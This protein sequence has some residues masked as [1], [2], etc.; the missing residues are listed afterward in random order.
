[1]ELLNI[2]DLQGVRVVGFDLYYQN[3]QGDIVVVQDALVKIAS[4]QMEVTSAGD[5]VS[6]TQIVSASN[7]NLSQVESVFL[8]NV[9]TENGAN[10]GDGTPPIDE[11][12]DQLRLRLEQE[13]AERAA[14][15]ELLEQQAAQLEEL[16]EE[17][18]TREAELAARESA[19]EAASDSDLAND[20]ERL[21]D[22]LNAQAYITQLQQE[23][24]DLSE[25][26]S[27]EAEAK[28]VGD[29]NGTGYRK[30]L[31]QPVVEQVSVLASRTSNRRGDVEEEEA[32]I[33]T[34][35]LDSTSD[36][37][38]QGDFITNVNESLRFIGRANPGAAVAI[39]VNGET[40]LTTAD[41]AGTWAIIAN[42]EF[43]DGSYPVIVSTTTLQ[44]NSTTI[45]KLLVIDTVAPE[46]PSASLA[47]ESDTGAS[48]SD[49][50]TNDVFAIFEGQAEPTSTV[51]LTVDGRTYTTKASAE[52][53][54]KIQALTRLTDE[55]DKPYQVTSEDVA[56]NQSPAFVD[57][58]TVDT[59]IQLEGGLMAEVDSNI[60]GDEVT[61]H[62]RPL[63][64]GTADADASVVL[65]LD[66]RVWNTDV[67]EDGHWTIDPDIQL[68]DGRYEYQLSATD[69]AGNTKLLDKVLVIDTVP[70]ELSARLDSASDSGESDSD[71]ITNVTTPR[72]SG[73][74][75][76]N[77]QVELTINESV[78]STRSNADGAWFIQ[79][80]E[81]LDEG[82]YEYSAMATDLAGNQTLISSDVTIDVRASLFGRLAPES[83]SGLFDDDQ[84][85]KVNQPKF[86]G[87]ADPGSVVT[88]TI[89]NQEH[90]TRSDLDGNWE[91]T[92]SQSLPDGVYGYEITSVD[93]AGNTALP[94]QNSVVIDTVIDLTARLDPTSDTGR[95][96]DDGITN[97]QTPLLSGRSEAGA[98]VEL[99]VNGNQYS[100]TV[101]Q[102]NTWSIAIPDP[103]Q[104]G[105]YD[106]E[107]TATDIAGNTV[108]VMDRF[109]VDTLVPVPFTAEL[110]PAS[111]SG[112][113]ES[114]HI[115]NVVRP[116]FK[117][118]AEADADVVLFMKLG[119]AEVVRTDV[120]VGQDLAWE[121]TVPE[122][123]VDGQYD[124]VLHAVDAAGNET[125]PVSGQLIIDTVLELTGGLDPASDTGAS[126]SD[127][128][129]RINTPS[130]SGEGEPGAIVTL[131]LGDQE[132]DTKVDE[133]GIWQ[134]QLSEALADGDYPY[135]LNAV[136][137]AG[138][139]LAQPLTDTIRIDTID[140]LD[141][142]AR[143]APESD[144]GV[145][146]SDQLTAISRPQ[147]TGTVEPGARVTLEIDGQQ[148]EANV[149]DQGS[150]TVTVTTALPDG[151]HAYQVVAE[152]LAGNTTS[153]TGEVVIDTQ[154]RLTGGLA[155]FSDTGVSD[156]D[157]LTRDKQ[158]T[159]AGTAEPQA[160]VTLAIAEQEYSTQ[161][162]SDGLWQIQVAEV[163]ADDEYSYSLISEDL[164]G[165]TASLN[166][167][168]E[169]DSQIFLTARLA[170]QSDS[171]VSSSDNITNITTPILRGTAEAGALVTV[172]IGGV[173]YETRADDNEQWSVQVVEPLADGI[174]QY[175]VRAEDDAG[176]QERVEQAFIVDTLAP[177]LT[178][179][180]DQGSDTG[181][182]SVDGITR[183]NTPTFSGTGEPGA[184]LVLTLGNEQ[185]ET[186]IDPNG[187]W[188]VAIE[189]PL[190]DGPYT[191]GIRASD[192]AGN[193]S[194]LTG[195]IHIDTQ[196]SFT[197]RLTPDSDTGA[198]NTDGITQITLPSFDGTGDAGDQVTLKIASTEYTTTVGED[199]R[200]Q[201]SVTDELNEGVHAYTLESR[202]LAGNTSQILDSITVDTTAPLNFTGGLAPTSD[203]GRSAEDG[204]TNVTR[205]SFSGLVEQGAKVRL[206]INDIKYDAEVS[207]N[208]QW[209]VTLPISLAD[210]TY[211]YELIATDLAGNK[212]LLADRIIV[213]TKTELSGGLDAESDSGV[214]SSDG[215]TNVSEPIFSGLGEPNAQVA[216]TIANRTYTSM[217]GENGEWSV[218]VDDT[219]VD[220]SHDYVITATDVAGNTDSLNGEIRVD[221]Q[222]SLTARL[223][224][225]SDSGWYRDDG[226]TN[227][228]RPF[229]S[230]SGE[231]GAS[232]ELTINNQT[233]QTQV[234]RTGQWSL[235]VTEELAD[236]EHSYHVISLDD[237]GNE[238]QASGTVV[239]DTIA[240]APLTASL[241]PASDSG[242]SSSDGI[243]NVST[244][245]LVGTGEEGARISVN[246]G[247]HSLTATVSEDGTWF[248]D[249]PQL[250]ADG[251]IHYEVLQTDVAGNTSTL[252]G[253]F[254]LDTQMAQI[255]GGLSQISDSGRSASDG[256]TNVQQPRFHGIAEK[257]ALVTLAIANQ[258]FSTTADG[259]GNWSIQVDENLP[260]GPLPY[261]ITGED[262]AGNTSSL[263]GV[264]TVDTQAPSPFTAALSPDSDTG[265]SSTD[266]ITNNSTPTFAGVAE[267][268]A[269]IV[270]SLDGQRLTT[271]AGD[272]GQWQVTVT[273]ELA[274][275]EYRFTAVATDIA[276][277]VTD[278]I[279]SAFEIDLDTF[280]TGGLAAES[281]TGD[282][283]SDGL[284]KE[285][286]PV[287]YGSTEVGARVV[288]TIEG[289]TIDADV[290]SQG[291]WVARVTDPLTEG[292]IEYRM[293]AT[294]IAGN[295]ATEVGTF[296]LDTT[297][298]TPFTMVL[299]EESDSGAI[300]DG[301]TNEQTPTFTGTGEAGALVTL[302][303]DGQTH[304]TRVSSGGVWSITFDPLNDGVKVIQAISSDAAGNQTT[305][306]V[307]DLTIDTQTSVTGRLSA[308]S[309]LGFSNSD[310]ITS[311]D[312]PR[313]V[314]TG[315]AG[316]TVA[317]QIDDA[318][319]ETTVTPEGN[320]QID[321]TE[322][323][324]EGTLDYTITATD[325]ADNKAT[326]GG[327][328]VIDRTAPTEFTGRLAPSSDTGTSNSDGLT[329]DRTPEFEGIGEPGARVT[330]LLDNRQTRTTVDEDGNWSLVPTR[331]LTSDG[332][333]NYV[334]TIMD[335]AGNTRSL[336]G[337][338]VLDTQAQLTGG[339]DYT[340]DTGISMSDRLTN[341]ATPMFSGTADPN[342]VVTL[343]IEGEDYTTTAGSNGRWQVTVDKALTD[344]SNGTV[345]DY[346]IN[347][348]DPAGN[349]ASAVEGNFTLDLVAPV[350]FEGG[351]DARSDLGASNSDGITNDTTPTFSGVV[352]PGSTV[353]LE[354]NNKQFNATV[355]GS[356]NWQFSLPSSEQLA[357]GV[358]P[359]T[360]RATDGAGNI[361]AINKTLTID[362]T[363]PELFARL[364]PASDSGDSNQDAITNIVTPS[365][366]G[367]TEP[368]AVVELIIAGQA[369]FASVDENGD[370]Q[371]EVTDALGEGTHDYTVTAIDLAGNQTEQKQTI[372][373]D[374]TA[375]TPFTARLD[376]S[377]DSGV[378]NEDGLTNIVRPMISGTAEVDSHIKV[379]IGGQEY[380]TDADANGA[381]SVQV[382]TALEQGSHSFTAT[383]TDKAGN[384]T[385][386]INGDVTIDTQTSVTGRLSADSDTG[387]SNSD[388]LTNDATP[389]FNGVAE[390]GA[391]VTLTIGDNTYSAAVDET[392]AWV[393]N[394][395]DTL[396][397]GNQAYRINSTDKAGNTDAEAGVIVVDTTAP[398]QPFSIIL[399]RDSDSGVSQTDGITRI[400]APAFTGQA[401]VSGLVT[402]VI[403]GVTRSTTANESGIWRIAFPDLAEGDKSAQ[404]TVTD[405]AGNIA[406]MANYDFTID[407]QTYVSGA[408]SPESDT[409]FFSTDEISN[410][411]QPYF[412][413]V[414]EPGSSITLTIQDRTYSSMVSSDGTWEVQ[415]TTPLPEG[416]H[417]YTITAEDIAGNTATDVGQVVI[418]LTAPIGFSGGLDPLSDTGASNSDLLT[419]E[420]L[421]TFSGTSE[422]GSKVTLNLND[423]SITVD[424]DEQGTWR[425]TLDEPLVDQG[426]YN[427]SLVAEDIA[428]NTRELTGAFE[429]DLV[430]HLTGRLAASSD[431][432]FSNN[433]N[434]TNDTTPTFTGEAESG[435][436]VTLAINGQTYRTRLAD[437]ETSW[438]IQVTDELPEG[439]HDY[440]IES[441][442]YAGN[443]ATPVTG[444]LV[445]DTTAPTPF[446]GGLAQDSTSDTGRA[447]DDSITNNR[448]PT[449]TGTVEDG[450]KVLLKINNATFEASVEGTTWS[451]TLQPGQEL[452]ANGT[453]TYTVE[454]Q[455]QAGN[456]AQINRT[457]TL[458][459][460]APK[461]T[462]RLAAE[463]DTGRSN[464]DRITADT[465]PVIRGVSDPDADISVTFASTGATYET[466]ADQLGNWSITV[467]ESNALAEGVQTYTVS[468]TDVAGNRTTVNSEGFEVDTTAPTG[469]SARLSA[470]S[471]SA[472]E[473][474]S[475]GTDSDGITNVLAPTVSGSVEEGSSVRVTIA[476]NQYNAQ[477]DGSNWSLTLPPLGQ[478][479][480]SFSAVATDAAGNSTA[481]I[482]VAFTIDN[483]IT[484]FSGGLQ[485]ASDSGF[486][487][488]DGLTNVTQPT[489]A[490]N[491]E[492]GSVVLLTIG[493]TSY[494]AVVDP[495]TGNW[496][497]KVTDDLADGQYEYSLTAVDIAGN[498]ERL[499]GAIEIDTQISTE[500]FTIA[501]DPASDSATKGD[502]LTNINV[503]RVTGSGEP[504]ALITLSVDGQTRTTMVDDNG[505][506]SAELGTLVDGD[507]TVEGTQT[508][509][510]GNTSAPITTQFTVDTETFVTARLDPQ[511]DF[512]NS[513][514]DG[515]TNTEIPVFSGTGE[516]GST[517][518]LELN[519]QSYTATVQAGG[520]WSVSIPQANALSSG[521]YSYSVT[522][523]DLAGNSASASGSVTI[524]L[525]APTVQIDTIADDDVINIAE[526]T[527]SLTISGSTVGVE[528]N[529][530]L[531][532]TLN[533]ESYNT[534]V[535]D[536]QFAIE[537]PRGH[538]AQLTNSEYEVQAS[539]ADVAGNRTAATRTLATDLTAPVVAISTIAEDDYINADE[540]ERG[541]VINGL[542]NGAE[543]GQVVNISVGAS[544]YQTTVDN[545]AWRLA[546]SPE[547]LTLLP[548]NQSTRV[549]AS[550]TDQAG[551]PSNTATRDVIKDIT[552]P[553][554]SIGEIA[555]DNVINLQESQSPVLIT[556]TTEGVENGGQVEIVLNGKT[557]T[558]E[559]NNGSWSVEIGATDVGAL[560]DG[561]RFPV[562]AK[563]ADVAGNV[564]EATKSLSVDKTIPLVSIGTIS[565]DGNLNKAEAGQPIEISGTTEGVENG[566][567]VIVTLN[568]ASYSA[569]VQN[570]QW[571]LSI[572]SISAANL[573]DGQTY[574]VTADVKDRA[575]NPA[576]QAV[577]TLT[578]DFTSPTLTIDVISDD[579][580]INEVEASSSVIISGTSD[581]ENGQ[582]VAIQLGNYTTSATVQNGLWTSSVP[583]SV[584]RQLADGEY[585]VS[586]D[587]S[588]LAGN[589][590]QTAVQTVTLDT[591]TP[592]IRV[593]PIAGDGVLNA[594]EQG[595][596]L[597]ISGT[598]DDVEDGQQ[599]SV[600]LND[601]DYLA[602]VTDNAWSL[603]I[604]A[605]D[606]DRLED[607]VQYQ[608]EM[609]VLD[610]AG[611]RGS[612]SEMLRTDFTAP[613][614]T[615]NDLGDNVLNIAERGESLEITGV[616]EGAELGQTIRVSFNGQNYA[617]TVRADGVWTVTVPV[618]RLAT[619]E[620]D[621]HYEIQAN[622]SDSAGNPAV[623]A[624][625]NLATDFTPPVVTFDAISEDTG[626]RYDDSTGRDFYTSD[627][628][629]IFTG[630]TEAGA[631]V[632]VY[633]GNHQLLGQAVVESNGA[634]V[635]DHSNTVLSDGEHTF[636]VVATDAAGNDSS[637]VQ[638]LVTVDTA[639]PMVSISHLSPDTGASTSDGITN[640]QALRF[641]GSA[642]ANAWVE[643]S[644][645]SQAI[646]RVKS[647][648]GG[649]WV[650]DYSQTVIPEGSYVLTAVALDKAG[651]RSTTDTLEFEVDI[652]SP[653]AAITTMV[654]DTNINNDWHTYH[655][656]PGFSGS[657]D[658]GSTVRI[659]LDD[660]QVKVISQVAQSGTWTLSFE[661]YQAAL[662]NIARLGDGDHTIRLSVTDLAGNSATVNQAFV[663]DSVAP[664]VTID[665]I[666][667]DTKI[668]GD[669]Y[670]SDGTLTFSG[671]SE[672]GASV[673]LAINGNQI[674]TL[675][676][677]QDG[678]WSYQHNVD[679][680][681]GDYQLTATAYDLAGNSSVA[682]QAFTVDK[683][684]PD[685]VEASLAQDTGASSTDWVTQNGQINVTGIEADST[686]QYSTDGGARWQN[687]QGS[688][689]T[690]PANASFGVNQVQIKQIDLAG[691]ES[692][693][694][695]NASPI[696]T[697]TVV[698]PLSLALQE[699]TGIRNDDW[700]TQNRTLIVTGIESQAT[701]EYS[702]NHGESWTN[703]SGNSFS[704]QDNYSYAAEQVQVRQTDLAGNVSTVVKAPA[705]KVD[706][707]KPATLTV[708]M[709]SDTG[710]S[711][712]DWIS[713]DGQIN[714]SGVEANA[715]WKYRT[716]SD[717]PWIEVTS[718][719]SFVL[720]EGRYN[721]GE[722]QV[723]QEDLAG[724]VST[725]WTSPQTIEVDKT[726]YSAP[727][728]TLVDDTGALSNDWVTKDGRFEVSN[729]E[730][731][732]IWQYS[733]NGGASWTR[734]I[735]DS[736][737]VPEG[738]Y[739]SGM[740]QVLQTDVAGNTSEKWASTQRLT[741]DTTAPAL[742]SLSLIEDTGVSN[743][744]QYTQNGLIQVTGVESGA[745]WEYSLNNGATWV[746]G[747]TNSNQFQL[748]DNTTYESGRVQVRQ[749]D[750]AGNV[751]EA[752][753]LGRVV[754]DTNAPN[755]PTVVLAEDTGESSSDWISRN[756]QLNVGTEDHA[757]WFYSLDGGNTYTQ[758]A[759]SNFT[760]KEGTYLS[761]R[762]QVYQEDLAGNR[763]AIWVA[764]EI[765]IITTPPAVKSVKLQAGYDTGLSDN[766]MITNRTELKFEGAVDGNVEQVTVTFNGE[767]VV[768]DVNNGAWEFVPRNSLADGDYSISAYAT[769]IAGNVS[770]TLEEQV[771]VDTSN[772]EPP[773][774]LILVTDS[775]VQGDNKTNV[776]TPSFRGTADPNSR[777]DMTFELE[778]GEKIA[779]ATRANSVGNWT[780]QVGDELPEGVHNYFA[781][782]TDLAGNGSAS[783]TRG[784]VEIDLTPPILESVEMLNSEG[785]VLGQWLTN[786]EAGRYTVTGESEPNAKVLL[787][788]NGTSIGE[789]VVNEAGVFEYEFD[790]QTL[791]EG[792]YDIRVEA[793][794]E[795]GN[796]SVPYTN[797]LI[798]DR[799]I[800]LTGGLATAS[801]SGV[802]NNDGITF[803]TT[804]VFQGTTDPDATVTIAIQ[805]RG[806]VEIVADSQGEWRYQVSSDLADGTYTWEISAIDNAGNSTKELDRNL[807][808]TLRVDTQAP[809]LSGVA[810]EAEFI[811]GSD[812]ITTDR[813]ITITGT[814]EANAYITLTI[815]DKE[816][817]TRAEGTGDFSIKTTT[818]SYGSHTYTVL[819]S[820]A[821][822]NRTEF[823]DD[824]VIQADY[825]PL[826]IDL[827]DS[828]NS[829]SLDDLL[830]NAK[831]PI[832]AGLATPGSDVTLVV[833]NSSGQQVATYR[834]TPSTSGSWQIAVDQDLADGDY[835]FSATSS[836][837]G[838]Q[839]DNETLN[840][841][842]D[843]V[844]E[845]TFGISK[846]TDSSGGLGI[847]NASAVE[848]TGVSDPDAQVT[849]TVFNDSNQQVSI[850]SVETAADGS[851]LLAIPGL[852]DG[853]YK[854]VVS[855][856]DQAGNL[857]GGN[858]E[859]T[860]SVT[861]DRVK[862]VI[863]ATLHPEDD[864]GVSDSDGIT[865]IAKPRFTG[866][867]Q[868]NY[869]HIY[870]YVGNTSIN[871]YRED[872]QGNPAVNLVDDEGNWTFRWQ[873]T[874]QDGI[875]NYGV[876]ARDAAKN[877]MVASGQIQ[878][879]TKIDFTTYLEGDSGELSNDFITNNTSLVFKG[880]TEPGNVIEGRL[881]DS[882]N[883]LL[884]TV[885]ITA[886]N[887]G[888]Y[889]AD[890]GDDY[891]D[892]VYRVEFD[893]SDAAGNHFE[894]PID[895][896]KIDTAIDTLTL[897]FD[898]TSDTGN[899]ELWGESVRSDG[900]TR[901]ILPTF[902]G[903]GEP[904][905]NVS[906]TITNAAGDVLEENT[907]NVTSA[908]SWSY[909][910]N[911]SL[912]DGDYRIAATSKDIAG[913][914]SL[915]PTVFDFTVKTTDP[916]L[917]WQN[918]DDTNGDGIINQREYE[919]SEVPGVLSF[920]GTGDPGD[921]VS[922]VIA[923]Q[924]Y[925]T[926]VT[927][928]GTW[929]LKTQELPDFEYAFY[930]Q[931][932]DRAGN[933]TTENA[934]VILDSG[935]TAGI[936]MLLADDTAVK[937]DN[938]TKNP[939]PRFA[940]D[941]EKGDTLTVTVT[942]DSAD[943]E[944]F[945]KE[946]FVADSNRPYW[947]LPE[948]TVY[949][950][951]EYSVKVHAIDIG[952]NE[953]ISPGLTFVID[954][955]VNEQ[956]PVEISYGSE[957]D[958]R[959]A[960]DE[961][962][963]TNIGQFSVRSQ[964]EEEIYDLQIDPVNKDI[965]GD[966]MRFSSD[967][968][969]NRFDIR[970]PQ[971]LADGRHELLVTWVDQAGNALS[972]TITVDIKSELEVSDWQVDN[973]VKDGAF[974]YSAD[975]HASF[976]GV[977]DAGATV[978]IKLD[979]ETHTVQAGA[980]G[981]WQLTIEDLFDG[982]YT[983]SVNVNDQWGNWSRSGDQLLV[984]DTF[985]PVLTYTGGS[986][987]LD[988]GDDILWN[989][990]ARLLSGRTEPTAVLS[991]AIEG[992]EPQNLT[993]SRGRWEF[994]MAEYDDGA[995]DVEL[996]S[997]DQAGNQTIESFTITI[998]TLAPEVTDGGLTDASDTGLSQTDSIT[999]LT[1000]PT[1001][1002][1003]TG[1004]PGAIVTVTIEGEE[1005]SATSTVNA[1006]GNWSATLNQPLKDGTYNYR[1007]AAEDAA[1008]NTTEL[1009]SS[1010]L[1011]ID[1012][1013]APESSGVERPVNQDTV[1014]QGNL[1015]N[1016]E[1017]ALI[1018]VDLNGSDYGSAT[1019]QDGYWSISGANFSSGDGVVVSITD[1020]AGNSR[1021]EEEFT[1022]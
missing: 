429:L 127:G 1002:E 813:E 728:V 416:E 667:D 426:R 652:T 123:L 668:V 505:S 872:A 736:F 450:A 164:A 260:D 15:L 882:S 518:S 319:Y 844:N 791:N 434:V 381:W 810:V 969:D 938:I 626:H 885:S 607:G 727:I 944:V 384:T 898:S 556:G 599:L 968:V 396:T 981:A 354:L 377:S 25:R 540:A 709:E 148:Y 600:K 530:T 159:F 77:T 350:P 647:D 579:N 925:S 61:N 270:I 111:D 52:G 913:N 48:D 84:V 329:N 720:D 375:P 338:M 603:N 327:T 541:I 96:D 394:V 142:T 1021:T 232:I 198:S 945:F 755:T 288:L 767:E 226:V 960:I 444:S 80:E 821:A 304:S 798:V 548:N 459:T 163:L 281:D 460:E 989:D 95:E 211:Q 1022:I 743:S 303:G 835:V 952:L 263:E 400:T 132:F 739:A 19:L 97:D 125:S 30:V 700:V 513:S 698:E 793:Q 758:G 991:I 161:V 177:Q 527:R 143:L 774:S 552:P 640:S 311:D 911:R 532:V 481:P 267:A 496:T 251:N 584:I 765:D 237:A 562:V 253:S 82:T 520:T 471:D 92:L 218:Q 784:S 488:T 277:N 543:Q 37:G 503:P 392:G 326:I 230:G 266:L 612:L 118:T 869:N 23:L 121:L 269:E 796:A 846:E 604:P 149:S 884:E 1006:Q 216:V 202:D 644:I 565:E 120:R 978:Q 483:Q 169:I 379:T 85:T 850:Q 936:W 363:P 199:G 388:G 888:Q 829:G 998:D 1015:A 756:G 967:K 362:T 484:A 279:S 988:A 848:I 691:N 231:V 656:Q 356:G 494:S 368:G 718:G 250:T 622:V 51:K 487:N 4:G 235:Q 366:N 1019:V 632:K 333:Y 313:F 451:Y 310:G 50:I 788:R 762:V 401:E 81:A 113:S 476:G 864:T 404:V 971:N 352:E 65:T 49:K 36:S 561:D 618:A 408:M 264:I 153:L 502:N 941:T 75:E 879:K 390:V 845:L 544:Q 336:N 482:D 673:I 146:D 134:I 209:R 573:V 639:L 954:T 308:A 241:S 970:L 545:G 298:P 431:H 201:I 1017:G 692:P 234:G 722:L 895:N 567:S 228:T 752:R 249:V 367:T 38:V 78:Y 439:Q 335:V 419:N 631:S 789:A 815:D 723:I 100:T 469:F 493:D 470:A 91:I 480:H 860:G 663:I 382:D 661:E 510:A 399:E 244:P 705:I 677:P 591:Q 596:D 474:N 1008:G 910:P 836:Q 508:D 297:P 849:V 955:Q 866:T 972:D 912:T 342:S 566:I 710:R 391:T 580:Y 900:I 614:I 588:D 137:L 376:A 238:A 832:V 780:I 71:Q 492:L 1003:G 951:G 950:D 641:H 175:V 477:V 766:D 627:T 946:T 611:N 136:D 861:I 412:S 811:E 452:P 772:P 102:D 982:Y 1:M 101:N 906:I 179:G 609:A 213:D 497:A 357:E 507:W 259:N 383:A 1007:V 636:L 150:W 17:I 594:R 649:N 178:G 324:P 89:N 501:L 242:H 21:E 886:S 219:L 504:G 683:I 283:N 749:T 1020:V 670:T 34:A 660:V 645:N 39:I 725:P 371:V 491:V 887:S 224:N 883:S 775:G 635:Y 975:E 777:I 704:L 528:N 418:D 46:M 463:S 638:R 512:G 393:A 287:F 191:Y 985:A 466:R 306:L 795:A 707:T 708:T 592:V 876:I 428:G 564:T 423:R 67:Q 126:D 370:W 122:D 914:E 550:T 524:D 54:W 465:S 999:S 292:V 351:L 964:V 31:P 240:P 871:L 962:Y 657:A 1018:E 246:V 963:Y 619:L 316:A 443:I 892:D 245:R 425:A 958:Y 842:I 193:I 629:L 734:G 726:A 515:I 341:D 732:A 995:Y 858:D 90:V 932:E 569:E 716:R 239:I 959:G 733:L 210:G 551:N 140:P 331:E 583:S 605:G 924:T 389:Q 903:R 730:A 921:R 252:Q 877:E 217:V 671:T 364:S 682:T 204:I 679:L 437:G 174:I 421:P 812:D 457:M 665:A 977:T 654:E 1010:Q 223:Q 407:T 361:A 511:S 681:H 794:D 272:D 817:R 597:Y 571:S 742:L 128:V 343:T 334:L 99:V 182:S 225:T 88:L 674:T 523:V 294:D 403:D 302:T 658:E 901:N 300:G 899:V 458:D 206:V 929:Q 11:N 509:A 703:G 472:D 908:G 454:A 874:L 973:F 891:P 500:G 919:A 325:G 715:A 160:T 131:T 1009:N 130:F 247:N 637:S 112:S 764:P 659:Y 577:S 22:L 233:Y 947:S 760:L 593:N 348:I 801:D 176:N 559:V 526:A 33:L 271:I 948:G 761:G 152:D 689:F 740:L 385:A 576:V 109:V 26:I 115:T 14:Q 694:W 157:G 686:W 894:R 312:T 402:L 771:T 479:D 778:N 322:V 820:D 737:T 867:V 675:S 814:S 13:Q 192:L 828:T 897:Q 358:Y 857:V 939:N 1012:T 824:I 87:T 432:G 533:G 1016:E 701:W 256:I 280:V 816:F 12:G 317:L 557:Y 935:V 110:D 124:F 171:G 475:T 215:L 1005:A 546:L 305:A 890:F 953:A 729:L 448:L 323:L 851:Y 522:A 826:E 243:T 187:E 690:L 904:G 695:R 291:N 440:I 1011:I 992:G 805:G 186:T 563:V 141:F 724:N 809:A 831:R 770:N 116:T 693:V 568:D 957:G 405:P 676:T 114:D 314:G 60:V 1004:E 284:T 797:Q 514:Q 347:A 498:S 119:G 930:I 165:N 759:G 94:V 180:L 572:S 369:Y 464:S 490:G 666:A 706:T 847:T 986:T 634:W 413:G 933:I 529:Q 779:Y 859:Y 346:T 856:V 410:E 20:P 194:R 489:F 18:A 360:L 212:S 542:A 1001:F 669:F 979:N 221:T 558:G 299:A 976:S 355:T 59:Q 616:V 422:P 928:A 73:E 138:N 42:T 447:S 147:F 275:G 633:D 315:E 222:I 345:Y 956:L 6:I 841:T 731:Q 685:M 461:V 9:F 750:L 282:S 181:V 818:L 549:L 893:V 380:L 870:I 328:I 961:V 802:S 268:G 575:G 926:D 265:V 321:V 745:T 438:S 103:L 455:D 1014:I 433:D 630:T 41:E 773:S 531:T 151:E 258:A 744:D 581:A 406:T 655:T 255:Q 76:P 837:P 468:A 155:P 804:P 918:D 158:P 787:Y 741:V 664:T 623:P 168:I 688:S 896:I 290:D 453:V 927:E 462:S 170:E 521:D 74:T 79:L 806:P 768:V 833:S 993:I 485:A 278:P 800:E 786:D 782:T 873:Q 922:V 608:I 865:N 790:I 195:E 72:F 197:G 834:T 840:I 855:S 684:A 184:A 625:L 537:V 35:E 28:N 499:T 207:E 344:Q 560:T 411:T 931:A 435:S 792:T 93:I 190:S 585:L 162:G 262:V 32:V 273:D 117:G 712:S 915:E 167:R 254:V 621:S 45:N 589:T 58:F 64:A 862:P 570:G 651:N 56:G 620:S 553:Q 582:N 586:A 757:L 994:D 536:N 339:L 98:T 506:W 662:G 139:T 687:G 839:T 702:L 990:G 643:L 398:T 808:G 613:S 318:T 154:T 539:V 359:Y 70:P 624:V 980:D 781:L 445:L 427:Y 365:F 713:M 923:G 332:Q 446:T 83:D 751:G 414:G 387:V 456:I 409:G 295:T 863:T 63:F 378:S 208:G 763:S 615:I 519:N 696:V 748:A 617:D 24:Y 107:V 135:S 7:L 43:A 555:E 574:Q 10:I 486:S 714:V 920:S 590:A 276:G 196:L 721:A 309:D 746:D 2:P 227:V 650:F 86:I 735:G 547:Q 185:Y 916:T 337:Q 69:L 653:S 373:I 66:N 307:Y 495:M 188:E 397:E 823:S 417:E 881:Y 738:V 200:W 415:V 183:I 106:F 830:T 754:V 598:T 478:G 229:F 133:D 330:L 907:A 719:S 940:I 29:E 776:A 880:L 203:S 934:K 424:V 753:S 166:G 878:I 374:L 62:P 996:I 825:I 40:E 47:P 516:P 517:I 554:L 949:P 680:A 854:Y 648:A 44:G 257:G 984:V 441:T 293:E 27:S 822:G 943:G 587:V 646:G 942:K 340:S 852:T 144:T 248:V 129:T 55:V 672:P 602:T 997:R 286:Q 473:R 320:W 274:A 838:I 905:A 285:V 436:E 538:V 785:L 909:R 601:N 606:L 467:S 236:G 747:N 372:T 145:S 535:V 3:E 819:A 937:A 843:S 642:E 628:Q 595:L 104:D 173:S 966:W 214:S 105:E 296:T 799:T 172:S 769:D 987:D 717:A 16:R 156:S 205:P 53:D 610:L 395:T 902:A 917:T 449:F 5:A 889:E 261:T 783:S 301:L 8:E 853:D 678:L 974:Y 711:A 442:D 534:Q 965:S 983:V 875:Y 803:V 807:T 57:T 420:Q 430:A 699:D 220:G 386:P 68:A 1013:T 697:D 108:T 525:D 353:V 868:E 289:Q 578:T 827:T 189:T 1000:L 349:Q